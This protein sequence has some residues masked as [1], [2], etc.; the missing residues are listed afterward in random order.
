MDTSNITNKVLLDNTA[1]LDK[2]FKMAKDM[3]QNKHNKIIAK[4]NEY[5][6]NNP[7]IPQEPNISIYQ[8]M[9]VIKYINP[10]N[11]KKNK[12]ISALNTGRLL[13]A[14]EKKLKQYDLIYNTDT[15]QYI[16]NPNPIA[17]LAESASILNE[18]ISIHGVNGVIENP[19]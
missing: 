7:H 12:Y 19:L 1:L 3:T 18:N 14:N 11:I 4:Y 13:T 9:K 5:L 6:L 8:M 2:H 16:R 17:L 10:L 15:K